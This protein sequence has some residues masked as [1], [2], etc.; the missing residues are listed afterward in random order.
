MGFFLRVDD[1]H[2]S[3]AK[4]K[5]QG[6]EFLTDPRQESYGWVA[7]FRDIAGNKWDLL[8]NA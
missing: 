4:M 1:F 6:V 7:V 8:G 2:Q 3:Y 5:A